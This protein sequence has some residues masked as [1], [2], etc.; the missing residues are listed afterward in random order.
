MKLLVG[1]PTLKNQNSKGEK[2]NKTDN[3]EM[4]TEEKRNT[5]K[6]KKKKN[7]EFP[8]KKRRKKEK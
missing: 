7:K 1:K 6:E 8:Y 3:R 4:T 5:A 2:I